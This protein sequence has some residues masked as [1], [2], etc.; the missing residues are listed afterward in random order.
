MRF[1]V[2]WQ[3][4]I[5]SWSPVDG[6]SDYNN[7]DELNEM[8]KNDLLDL[9]TEFER[10]EKELPSFQNVMLACNNYF[11][12]DLWRADYYNGK[13]DDSLELHEKTKVEYL[14]CNILRKHKDQR[15]GDILYTVEARSDDDDRNFIWEAAPK[16]MLHFLDEPYGTDMFLQNAF[17]HDIRIPDEMFPEK[18]RNLSPDFVKESN[19]DGK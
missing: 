15:T 5:K 12:D 17:R 16:S 3:K 7:A 14:Y 9:P 8:L 13:L 18:W 1:V 2:A 4:H 6:A 11:S 19:Q 10:I